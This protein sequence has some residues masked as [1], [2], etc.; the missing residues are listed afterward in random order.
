MMQGNF[1]VK[2]SEL[3]WL[4]SVSLPVLLEVW[5]NIPVSYGCGLSIGLV[6]AQWGVPQTPSDLSWWQPWVMVVAAI[7]GL[8]ILQ[9]RVVTMDWFSQGLKKASLQAWLEIQLQQ[10]FS[11]TTQSSRKVLTRQSL[12]FP[13]STAFVLSSAK[14][15]LLLILP[16]KA[17]L[18]AWYIF[19]YTTNKGQYLKSKDVFPWY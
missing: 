12:W 15:I 3:S 4:S 10:I 9:H 1:S 11:W 18:I 8:W 16:Y 2:E 7:S 19:P 13:I 17:F 14:L 5:A 6:F